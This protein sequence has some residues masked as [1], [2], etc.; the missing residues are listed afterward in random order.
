MIRKKLSKSRYEI[1]ELCCLAVRGT[2]AFISTHASS[3]VAICRRILLFLAE[4]LPFL[5]EAYQNEFL[6]KNRTFSKVSNSD[7]T[8][9]KQSPLLNPLYINNNLPPLPIF[10]NMALITGL[11]DVA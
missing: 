2:A 5:I 11:P 8:N 6:P 9:P 10:Y 4:I 7:L 1:W 3:R